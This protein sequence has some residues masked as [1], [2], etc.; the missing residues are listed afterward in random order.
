MDSLNL[1]NFKGRSF[2]LT[3]KQRR[4]SSVQTSPIDSGC[5]SP[6]LSLP[7]IGVKFDQHRRMKSQP[8]LF[9]KFPTQDFVISPTQN[10]RLAKLESIF[11][12]CAKLEKSK[13]GKKLEKFSYVVKKDSATRKH[14]SRSIDDMIYLPDDCVDLENQNPNGIKL[15]AS[16]K[17]KNI[18]KHD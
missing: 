15:E 9:Q 18:F 17:M 16:R 4:F 12:S 6:K 10:D 5:N 8:G 3:R 1:R 2:D 14:L 13:L 11:T 7:R